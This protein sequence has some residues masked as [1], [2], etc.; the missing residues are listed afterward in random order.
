MATETAQRTRYFPW[1]TRVSLLLIVL[2][3]ALPGLLHVLIQID[4]G[5]GFGFWPLFLGRSGAALLV[6]AVVWMCWVSPVFRAGE[7][8]E[9][10]ARDPRHYLRSLRVIAWI[11]A[12]LVGLVLAVTAAFI[13]WRFESQP[14]LGMVRFVLIGLKQTGPEPFL[15]ITLAC[16]VVAAGLQPLIVRR[17]NRAMAKRHLCSRCGYDLHASV[18]ETCPECGRP[19]DDVATESARQVQPS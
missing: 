8:I 18:A 6:L 7:P 1:W 14:G 2:A 19:R 3:A 17:F 16:L 13:L 11:P 5:F 4:R 9:A 15:W 10:L 12:L